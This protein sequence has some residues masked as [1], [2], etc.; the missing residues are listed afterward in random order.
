MSIAAARRLAL[1]VTANACPAAPIESA[2]LGTLDEGDTALPLADPLAEPVGT[3]T[4]GAVA[5]TEFD[6]ELDSVGTETDGTET[7]GIEDG[8]EDGMETDGMDRMEM[9]G[10]TTDDDCAK[11]D[12]ARVKAVKTTAV[13]NFMMRVVVSEVRAVVKDELG[14]VR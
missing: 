14:V 6:A 7:D 2:E 1:S 10:T 8:I 3:L 12:G 11:A 4:G 13:E 9:G 5:E